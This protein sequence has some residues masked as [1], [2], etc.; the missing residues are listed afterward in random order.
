[1]MQ[2][3][4]EQTKTRHEIS[5]GSKVKKNGVPHV[6]R[7]SVD[8]YYKMDEA[9]MFQGRRVQLIGGEIIEMAPMGTTHSTAVRLVVSCLRKVFG[10]GFVVDSQLPLGLGKFDE[11]EPD[12]A[13][14]EGDIRDFTNVHPSTARLII[15]VA[16]S[17]LKLDRGQKVGLYAE[18]GIAEY[19]ILNLKQRQLEVFR[20]P[21][22]DGETADYTERLI[23]AEDDFVSPSER[24]DS[25]LKV[26]DMLP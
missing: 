6:I 3:V 1:M 15:E 14:I 26:K 24:P 16:D 25:R 7:W 19:W 22:F 4:L 8:E 10:D 21:V 11:P 12:V 17:S 18:N 2:T 23:I 20:K 5:N 9:G 13:I